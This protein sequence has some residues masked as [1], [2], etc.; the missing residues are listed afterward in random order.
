M[1]QVGGHRAAGLSDNCGK[2]DQLDRIY[3]INKIAFL[4]P[5]HPVNPVPTFLFTEALVDNG[6]CRA[7]P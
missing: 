3:R 4:N 6:L 7:F 2:H 1:L 5:V